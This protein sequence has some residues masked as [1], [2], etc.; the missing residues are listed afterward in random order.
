MTHIIISTIVGIAVLVLL[1][2]ILWGTIALSMYKQPIPRW[3]LNISAVL[4][5]LFILLLAYHLGIIILS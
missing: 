2:L 5:I 1:I 4:C 3:M